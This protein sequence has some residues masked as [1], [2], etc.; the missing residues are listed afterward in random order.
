MLGTI[1]ALILS[2]KAYVV[3]KCL[4]MLRFKQKKFLYKQTFFH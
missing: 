2:D 3:T 4:L 1:H